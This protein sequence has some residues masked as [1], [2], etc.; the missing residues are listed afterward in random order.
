MGLDLAMRRMLEQ[1]GQTGSML[2]D[3]DLGMG[4]TGDGQRSID[5]GL[6]V[7][8]VF[9]SERREEEVVVLL[10]MIMKLDD[11]MNFGRCGE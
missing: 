4:E 3:V 2:V 10:L 8:V 6:M 7:V 9:V 5:V 11:E 1:W